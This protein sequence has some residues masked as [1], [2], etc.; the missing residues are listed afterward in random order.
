M[1]PFAALCLLALASCAQPNN[2]NRFLAASNRVDIIVFN[3]GDTLY[4]DTQDSTGIDILRSQVTGNTHDLKDTC[5]AQGFLRFRQDSTL[6]LEANF[7]VTPGKSDNNC[8]YI[9]YQHDDDTY[10]QPLSDRAKKLLGKVV[11]R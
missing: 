3:G 8:N 9:A 10:V 7:A 1:K 4:F 6:L 2:Y 11:N 5:S